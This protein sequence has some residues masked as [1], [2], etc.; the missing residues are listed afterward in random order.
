MEI[1]VAQNVVDNLPRPVWVKNVRLEEDLDQDGDPI[2]R[3]WLEVEDDLDVGRFFDEIRRFSETV[4]QAL[5]ATG[6]SEWVAVGL[7]SGVYP[8]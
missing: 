4:T 8:E 7:D 3:V 1:S 2:M 6:I 5:K